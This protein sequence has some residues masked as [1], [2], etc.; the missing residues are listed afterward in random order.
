MR[1]VTFSSLYF[2]HCIL[3]S[4]SCI[5]SYNSSTYVDI[6]HVHSYR[7]FI[8]R[9]CC[10]NVCVS[11]K[12]VI[13]LS[14]HPV[15]SS[16]WMLGLFY[17]LEKV[18]LDSMTLLLCEI[19]GYLKEMCYFYISIVVFSFAK[20]PTVFFST[21]IILPPPLLPS[22]SS[23]S[24]FFLVFFFLVFLLFFFFPIFLFVVL[25]MFSFRMLTIIRP[26]ATIWTTVLNNSVAVLD[27]NHL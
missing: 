1:C 27:W 20:W 6:F 21:E 14:L 3:H 7:Y 22:Y 2:G 12:S 19:I 10:V 4:L 15:F 13:F 23:A 8:S 5:L 9:I 25:R 16:Y 11:W 17:T 18:Y 26:T 24:F